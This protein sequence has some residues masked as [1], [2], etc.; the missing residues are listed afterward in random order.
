MSTVPYVIR[1]MMRD[2]VIVEPPLNT[3]T[4]AGSV[5]AWGVSYYTTSA[6]TTYA[7]RTVWKAKNVVSATGA[8]VVSAGHCILGTDVK[9]DNRARITLSSVPAGCSSQPEILNVS[10]S[11]AQSSGGLGHPTIYF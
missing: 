6:A 4:S 5:G 3:A 1:K 10:Y 2:T 7:C 8:T 11:P 9:I